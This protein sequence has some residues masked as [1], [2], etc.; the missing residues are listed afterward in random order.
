MPHVVM[1]SED[2][3]GFSDVSQTLSHLQ[4]NGHDK[5]KNVTVSPRSLVKWHCVK[6]GVRL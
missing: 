3:C 1:H 4:S 6:L 5:L 2:S